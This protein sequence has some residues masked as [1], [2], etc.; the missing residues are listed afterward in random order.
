MPVHL[1]YTVNEMLP[2]SIKAVTDAGDHFIWCAEGV[3][4]DIV[5]PTIEIP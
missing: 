2:T 4:Q 5:V 3:L 1:Y